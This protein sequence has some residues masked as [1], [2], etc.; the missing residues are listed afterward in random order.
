M[1]I[2]IWHHVDRFTLIEVAY[3]WCELPPKEIQEGVPKPVMAIVNDMLLALK[4]GELW[5]YDRETGKPKWLVASRKPSPFPSISCYMTLIYPLLA[6]KELRRWALTRDKR[7][8][9]LFPE[10]QPSQQS[11]NEQCSGNP[12]TVLNIAK[13]KRVR[14]T[15]IR[16]AVEAAY[17]ALKT[18][19]QDREPTANEVFSY[20]EDFDGTGIIVDAK[21]DALVWQDT[22]GQ[23]HDASR[24]S[25]QNMLS[26]IRNKA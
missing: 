10:D 24:K 22:K 3:L 7:P 18:H 2:S 16:I 12:L 21:S 11:K 13:P 23:L 6:R 15:R 9:F 25:I 1:D 5:F 8:G 26:K 20:L 19:N 14:K 17:I 4:R